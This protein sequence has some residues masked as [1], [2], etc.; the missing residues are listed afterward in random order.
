MAAGG[1]R[2]RTKLLLLVG[3]GFVVVSAVVTFVADRMMTARINENQELLF[4]ERLDS[5]VSTLQRKQELLAKTGM[6]IAYRRGVKP[7]GNRRA[8]EVMGQVFEPGAANWRG[9][10]S[11]PGSGLKLREEYRRFDAEAAFDIQTPPP[12]EPQGCICGE[13]L[14]GVKTP[15]DCALFRKT[16]RPEQP[17]GPCMVSPEGSC[18]AFYQYGDEDGG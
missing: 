12:R 4:A 15:R 16:C 2:I 18:S 8:L 14:R 7:E 10:G 13:I 17:V 11:I 6:E 9:V 1:M 3:A 5:I